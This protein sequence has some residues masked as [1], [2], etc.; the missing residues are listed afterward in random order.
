MKQFFTLF[1]GACLATVAL[2]TVACGGGADYRSALPAD[3]FMTLSFNPAALSEKSNAGAFADSELFARI[4]EEL[5]GVESLSAEQKEYYLSLLKNPAETGVDMDR[6]SYMFFTLEG[7]NPAQ[8][9]GRGGLLLPLADRAKFDAFIAQVNAASGLEVE[10]SGTISYVRVGEQSDV[11]VVCAFNEAACMLFVSQENPEECLSRVKDLFAQKTDKSLIGNRAIAERL[12]GKN[13][14]NVVLSYAALMPML[15]SNPMVAAMPAMEALGGVSLLGSMNFEK[16]RIVV[17]GAMAFADDAA[18]AKLEELYGYVMPQTGKL[19]RYLPAQS[20]AA[21]GMGLN[22]G[23]L[24]TMLSSMPGYGMLMAN[25]MVKQVMEA[26]DGDLLLGFSGMLPG[27][28]YPVASLLAQVKDAGVMQLLVSNLGG[29]PLVETAKD[30][31]S[32]SMGGVSAFFGVKDNVLY[33][34]SDA[35]VKTALDGSQIE[36]FESHKELFK[37]QASSFFVDFRGVVALVGQLTAGVGATDGARMALEVLGLFNRMELSG[38]T[39]GGRMVVY[40]TDGERNA[41]ETI[42]AETGR[43]IEANL[44]EANN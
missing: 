44:P 20:I 15:K 42:C 21:M 13:D 43:L 23:K 7:E 4:N 25:P 38:T 19:L 16:G 40:M 34:T 32:I 8:P 22:G 31:Y 33:I 17:D 14:I 12:A 37:D 35:A 28:Q 1:K 24:F 39:E 41:L 30:Q 3:A 11:S 29:M 9:T 18:K 27:G 6:D 10:Q 36:S 2:L 5:A 26:F